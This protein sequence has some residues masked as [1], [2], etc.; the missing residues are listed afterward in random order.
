M[1]S[2]QEGH[3][4]DR[5]LGVFLPALGLRARRRL[6]ERGAILVDGHPARPGFRVRPGQTILVIPTRECWDDGPLLNVRVVQR[7][8]HVVALY[9]P[10]GLHTACL[11]GSEAPCVEERLEELLGP[12]NNGYPAVVNRLDHETSG[13][14]AAALDAEGAAQWEHAENAGLVCKS[15]LAIAHGHI[16]AP[17]V[18]RTP[19]DTAD[20]RISRPIPGEIE[21]PLR[22]TSVT[23]LA[24]LECFTAPS[25]Q[26]FPGPL[27][28]VGCRIFKGARHQIRVHLSMNGHP[29]AGDRLYGS[30]LP[31]PF[32][33]HH[34]L[35]AFNDIRARVLPDWL[36][37]LL[38]TVTQRVEAWLGETS[39][40]TE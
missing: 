36:G 35:F 40:V 14:V 5:A 17:F 21:T 18:E 37:S 10:G 15:Y 38:D 6:C 19:L 12:Q 30:P 29:L 16:A 32:F 34:A 33:L 31:G 2:A 24:W 4:L 23:P 1:G 3:R 25:G 7:A 27:T 26:T 9:K 22:Q 8:A 39:F 28:L 11:A 20:R 13:L